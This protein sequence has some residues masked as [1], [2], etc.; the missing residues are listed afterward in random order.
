[1]A[2]I[3]E[4]RWKKLSDEEKAKFEEQAK[5]SSQ[6]A[7]TRDAGEDVKSPSSKRKRLSKG[8]RMPQWH[9]LAKS[10][11]LSAIYRRDVAKAE[12]LLRRR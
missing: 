1:M 4:K 2:E 9:T 11:H 10:N 7:H 5:D 3:L 8:E 12:L 6:A